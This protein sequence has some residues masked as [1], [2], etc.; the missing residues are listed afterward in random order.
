MFSFI[1]ASSL[2]K[3]LAGLVQSPPTGRAGSM[4]S[5]VEV[6]MVYRP[7]RFWVYVHHITTQI[8]PLFTFTH[9]SYT[10]EKCRGNNNGWDTLVN[11]WENSLGNMSNRPP[12]IF[13]YPDST[14][15]ESCRSALR[16]EK[17]T[18][19]GAERESLFKRGM[20]IIMGGTGKKEAVG[21]RPL[22]CCSTSAA[23]KDFAQPSGKFT[24][25]VIPWV[26][27]RRS[28]K[29]WPMCP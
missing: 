21:A 18:T 12:K 28:F 2:G 10:T 8:H 5:A 22:T 3:E 1:C 25:R 29:N 20:Q 23:D 24:R 9:N 7:S 17:Q 26:V 6:L 27:P 19:F 16:T 14:L 13:V 15:D 11:L 4:T